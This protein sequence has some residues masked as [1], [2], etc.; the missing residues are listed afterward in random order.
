MTTAADRF[1]RTGTEVPQIYPGTERGLLQAARDTCA[2]SIRKEGE[3]VLSAVYGKRKTVI[4]IYE[5][6]ECVYDYGTAEG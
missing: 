3:H 1:L 5:D 2:A 4:Q 6:S